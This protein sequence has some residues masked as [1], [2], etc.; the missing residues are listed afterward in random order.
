MR[1]RWRH[2]ARQI[3]S[4]PVSTK[5][6][7]LETAMEILSEVFHAR[8]ADVE[9]MILRRLEERSCLDRHEDGLWPGTFCLGE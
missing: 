1:L 9:E 2:D 5:A 3:D 8:P 6:L 7:E 4:R